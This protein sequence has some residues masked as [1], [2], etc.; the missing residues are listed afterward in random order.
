MTRRTGM[1]FLTIVTVMA[2]VLM[3]AACSPKSTTK[4]TNPTPTPIPLSAAPLKPTYTVQK[5][6]VIS[7]IQFTGRISPVK[8]DSL[9]FRTDGRVRN[10]YV[11]QGDSVKKGQILADL[12]VLDGL[13]RKQ[14]L[15]TFNLRRA[16]IRLELARLQLEQA[17]ASTTQDIT[18][19]APPKNY[20][21]IMKQYQVEL[22]QIDLDQTKIDN[23]DV[24]S[25][26]DAAQI[27]ATMDGQVLSVDLYAGTNAAAYK[28]GVTIGDTTQM[29]VVAEPS[30][31]QLN[32]LVEGQ[33]AS[34]VASY[35]P[36]VAL[37]GT[38]RQLPFS[39]KTS[40]TSD[41]LTHIAMDTDPTQA[42]FTYNDSVRVTI[43]LQQKQ[44]VLWLPIQ[45]VRTFEGRRFVVVQDGSIQRRVD[46]KV[47]ITGEDRIEITE[48]LTEGQ[49]VVSP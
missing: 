47:G 1:S 28:P 3:A 18:T 19:Q 8:V 23:E 34:M 46:V 24:Q 10:V 49:I 42:G 39:G 35:Q 29:E 33:P 9:F 11:K 20:D 25:T 14:A 21:I 41:P 16:E 13:Q 40:A 45:A 5:G 7:L 27:V 38:I 30:S 4:Q 17:Q 44:D 32:Q 15:N 36:G 22:A 6:E 31:D 2:I 26:I 37:T 48:G 12:E 43:T